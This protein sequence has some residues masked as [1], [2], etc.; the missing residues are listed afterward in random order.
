VIAIAI[1]Q[2]E[3]VIDR[4]TKDKAFRA[5]YCRDPD[6][7]LAEYLTPDEIHAIKTGNGE[8]LGQLGKSARWQ[9][10]SAGLCGADPG[11]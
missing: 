9:E 3:T 4:L 1:E 6:G 8:L 2:I 7:T 11:P 5:K 10:L